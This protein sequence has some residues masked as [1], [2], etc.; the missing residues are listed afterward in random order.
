MASL[1]SSKYN[2]QHNNERLVML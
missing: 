2:E 1:Y